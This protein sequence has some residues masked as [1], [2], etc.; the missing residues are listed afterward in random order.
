M[1]NSALFY[2]SIKEITGV[3]EMTHGFLSGNK[4]PDWLCYIIVMV[5]VYQP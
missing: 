1:H 2:T 4:G 5:A 3:L